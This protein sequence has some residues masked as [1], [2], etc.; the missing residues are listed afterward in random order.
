MTIS[1]SDEG[2]DRIPEGANRIPKPTSF[3]ESGLMS[4]VDASV[5]QNHQW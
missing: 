3:T 2:V 1:P 4:R 5:G